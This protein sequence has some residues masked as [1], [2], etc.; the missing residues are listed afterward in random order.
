MNLL[1]ARE[2]QGLGTCSLSRGS[3]GSCTSFWLSDFEMITRSK[4]S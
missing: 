4:S 3:T 1:R 2:D